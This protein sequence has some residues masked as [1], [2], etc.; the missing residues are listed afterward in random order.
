MRCTAVI[1]ASLIAALALVGGCKSAD[2]SGQSSRPQQ[3]PP[4]PLP[5]PAPGPGS[6]RPPAPSPSSGNAEPN[7]LPSPSPA[8]TQPTLPR[9]PAP[10]PNAVVQG[11]FTVYTIPSDPSP[12]QSY[13]IIIEVKLPAHV[14]S[15]DKND[16]SGRVIGTDGYTQSIGSSADVF[17]AQDQRFTFVPGRATLTVPVPGAFDFVKDTIEVRSRTLNEGQTITITF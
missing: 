2:F 12:G 1:I 14:T 9:P 4:A 8:D 3:K 5:G 11:S 16:L 7:P 17:D 10:P 13:D 6:P 15:I